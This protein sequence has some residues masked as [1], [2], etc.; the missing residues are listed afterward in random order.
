MTSKSKP[1]FQTTRA[2]RLSYPLY[3]VGQNVFFILITTFLNTYLMDIGIAAIAISG[4]FL[5]V[6][7]WDAVNDPIFGGLVDKLNL[8]G[9]K[10]L[11][12]L[13]VSV[14]AI[15]ISTLLLFLIDRKSTRL[16]SSH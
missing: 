9:G 3:F 6:K 16:N 15:P 5:V 2:E 10:F 12:W 14:L 1:A 13:R 8:K 4:L 11:P 7:I